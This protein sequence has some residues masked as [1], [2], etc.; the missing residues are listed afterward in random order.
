MCEKSQK[1]NKKNSGTEYKV[2]VKRYVSH[3]ISFSYFS[4][5][6]SLTRIIIRI[7]LKKYELKKDSFV[8]LTL[9]ALI[10]L[11]DNTDLNSHHQYK[12]QNKI[13]FI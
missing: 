7:A 9:I 2:E 4:S 5:F 13:Y 3:N 8:K 1:E 10:I 6:F 11:S 12:L